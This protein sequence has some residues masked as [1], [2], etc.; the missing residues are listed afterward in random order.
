MTWSVSSCFITLFVL[1]LWRVED[2]AEACKCSPPHPQQA[3]CNADVVVSF[4]D[5][6]QTT[7]PRPY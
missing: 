5:I 7:R 4:C 1:F 2:I 3:F 6:W